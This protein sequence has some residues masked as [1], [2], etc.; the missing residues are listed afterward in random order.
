M[1]RRLPTALA[2]L[3]LCTALGPA[4]ADTPAFVQALAQTEDATLADLYRARAFAP[5]WTGAQHADRRAA[6]VSALDMAD[7]HGLP[8]AR[9]DP[10]PL[11]AQL[12]AVRTEADRAAADAAA[13]HAVL[14]LARDLHGGVLD[15]RRVDDT[16]RRSRP[17]LDTEALLVCMDDSRHESAIRSDVTLGRKLGIS[18]T[19]TF[20]INGV[21]LSGAQPVERFRAIIDREL[22]R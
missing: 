16:I 5:L 6:L 3:A 4:R 9:H 22:E 12:A 8:A 7:L 18:A 15:P 11:I 19:P 14:R 13:T 20:F 1:I 17:T 21:L 10:A 2:A